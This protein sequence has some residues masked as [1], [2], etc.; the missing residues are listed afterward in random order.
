MSIES[1]ENFIKPYNKLD[2]LKRL[3][4]LQFIPQNAH[5]TTT[6]YYLN[7]VTL[8]QELAT[9]KDIPDKKF[10][11]LVKLGQETFGYLDDPFEQAF[12]E[13]I[14]SLVAHI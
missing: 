12:T 9:K 1:I 14:S 6:L 8:S 3:S 5:Y 11:E 2:L 13:E 4:T 10:W 7:Q